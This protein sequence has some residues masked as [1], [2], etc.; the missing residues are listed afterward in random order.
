M[1]AYDNIQTPVQGQPISSSQFGARVKAAIQDLDRRMSAYDATTGVGKVM[2][3]SNLVIATTTETAALTL[4]G[5]TFRAGYA[6]KAT[7]RSGFLMASSTY[8]A[9]FR[10]R[11]YNATPASGADWGEYFRFNA[12]VTS[13]GD[14][15]QA[16]GT[17]YLLNATGADITSDVNLIAFSS[18]AVASALTIWASAASPRYLVIEPAG[19]ATDYVGMGVQVS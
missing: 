18:N 8:R 7:Y 3:T 6:Y 4:T 2:S 14:V 16:F 17:I 10:L 5:F 15:M 9:G 11:K 13:P 19:F 12:A 1:G